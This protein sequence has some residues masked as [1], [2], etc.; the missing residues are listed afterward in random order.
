MSICLACH[1]LLLHSDSQLSKQNSYSSLLQH[2][3]SARIIP[4]ITLFVNA[5]NVVPLD[6]VH[7]LKPR[8]TSSK[9]GE[10]SMV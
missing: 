3:L 10:R 9:R 8:Y 6:A 7:W 1:F 4:Y 2:F 5:R